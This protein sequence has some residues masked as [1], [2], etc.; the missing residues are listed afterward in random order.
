MS[1]V[2]QERDR[3][4]G[5][6][7]AVIGVVGFVIMV[8]AIG[9]A[10]GLLSS[11]GR[12]APYLGAP[13]RAVGEEGG[14]KVDSTSIDIDSLGLRLRAEQQ[15]KL[16]RYEWIDRKNGVARIPIDRAI[17]IVAAEPGAP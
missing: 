7:A 2:V 6:L 4:R 8:V 3:I 12:R 1:A 16:T 17:D 13:G 5:R 10:W 14:T 9:A 15:K 11:R